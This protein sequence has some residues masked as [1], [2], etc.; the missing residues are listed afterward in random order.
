[1]GMHTALPGEGGLSPAHPLPEQVAGAISSL[2]ILLIIVKLGKLFHDLPKVSPHP[3]RFQVL[4]RLGLKSA[5]LGS[6]EGWGH[7]VR[8]CFS[9]LRSSR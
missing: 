9:R 3:A 7:K 2:F 5:S 4:A 6:G 1:M 8:F